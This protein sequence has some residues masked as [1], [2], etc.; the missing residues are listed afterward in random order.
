MNQDNQ[1]LTINELEDLADT[2]EGLIPILIEAYDN[3][4]MQLI[5]WD[6][7]IIFCQTGKYPE[8]TSCEL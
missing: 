6:A 8:E 4:V 2:L 7:F 3:A 1:D 5:R